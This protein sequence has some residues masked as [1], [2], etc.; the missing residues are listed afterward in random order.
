MKLILYLIVLMATAISVKACSESSDC[1]TNECCVETPGGR[2]VCMGYR[3]NGDQCSLR[4]RV[5]VF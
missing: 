2:N 4:P 5:P 1:A 3:G